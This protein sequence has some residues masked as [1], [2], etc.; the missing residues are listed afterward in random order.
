MVR[1][2]LQLIRLNFQVCLA[3]KDSKIYF[4]LHHRHRTLLKMLNVSSEIYLKI[5]L[6]YLIGMWSM[7]IV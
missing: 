6:N 1:L 7:H 2:E 4:I 5:D 3:D